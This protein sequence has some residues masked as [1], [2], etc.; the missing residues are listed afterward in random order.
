MSGARK[1]VLSDEQGDADVESDADRPA[2]TAADASPAKKKKRTQRELLEA[3]VDADVDNLPAGTDWKAFQKD[4]RADLAKQSSS[5]RTTGVAR[6]MYSAY[7]LFGEQQTFEPVDFADGGAPV[8]VDDDF[9]AQFL[10]YVKVT[11]ELDK[12]HRSKLATIIEVSPREG[13][14]DSHSLK[15][16]AWRLLGSWAV[17]VRVTGVSIA[18]SS[19]TVTQREDCRP[20]VDKAFST[21]RPAA[22]EQ[23]NRSIT[24]THRYESRLGA[25]V[26]DGLPHG[27]C[28]RTVDFFWEQLY[29][30]EVKIVTP[31]I[32]PGPLDWYVTLQTTGGYDLILT[33]RHGSFAFKN[34]PAGKDA[35]RVWRRQRADETWA[36][37]RTAGSSTLPAGRNNTAPELWSI[38]ASGNI[39]KEARQAQVSE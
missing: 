31:D 18:L 7:T 30:I 13:F 35:Q 26:M 16:I 19:K 29:P 17:P 21:T 9:V 33:A 24:T 8:A 25:E 1:H 14:A 27:P 20:T 38:D 2:A 6:K 36:P 39:V 22:G 5:S 28:G 4:V 12:T 37:A 15:H 3:L 32:Q 34:G 11:T 10:S 23:P